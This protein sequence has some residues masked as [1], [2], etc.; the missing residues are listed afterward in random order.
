M[1]MKKE[2]YYYVSGNNG[3]DEKAPT[4]KL[5]RQIWLGVVGSRV[6]ILFVMLVNKL[7]VSPALS[8]I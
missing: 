7:S 6:L 1:S 8:I 2:R 5:I 4:W 3:D